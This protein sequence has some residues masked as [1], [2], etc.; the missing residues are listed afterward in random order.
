MCEQLTDS[1][2]GALRQADEISTAKGKA[3]KR[4][5]KAQSA[6]EEEECEEREHWEECTACHHWVN[7]GKGREELKGTCEQCGGEVKWREHEA[8]QS[9]IQCDAC[10]RWRTVP[11]TVLRRVAPIHEK[12][13]PEHNSVQ[14]VMC[15][16]VLLMLSLRCAPGLGRA[17][18]VP[19]VATPCAQRVACLAENIVKACYLVTLSWTPHVITSHMPA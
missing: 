19:K 18:N 9:W 5:R 4:K 6:L 2:W 7:L 15:T 17:W 13:K 16:Y 8:V 14:G 11:D 3:G 12:L 1:M 10:G